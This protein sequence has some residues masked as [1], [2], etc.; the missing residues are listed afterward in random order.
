MDDDYMSF[1]EVASEFSRLIWIVLIWSTM[2][3]FL[4]WPSN[5]YMTS[6][7]PAGRPASGRGFWAIVIAGVICLVVIIIGY[8]GLWE[9]RAADR[10]LVA[11]CRVGLRAILFLVPLVVFACACVVCAAMF[12]GVI[13][14]QG[15]GY[16]ALYG[17]VVFAWHYF[18]WM[19]PAF[20]EYLFPIE[21][22]I[23]HPNA[24]T[25]M[26]AQM[27]RVAAIITLTGA[28]APTVGRRR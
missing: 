6:V 26:L 16:N 14:Y 21:S 15:Y 24:A 22:V 17:S 19:G 5:A 18:L 9:G 7:P 28:V 11:R 4:L 12:H 27:C 10:S 13:P 3:W 1:R 23:R 8:I 2:L 20:A 25:E